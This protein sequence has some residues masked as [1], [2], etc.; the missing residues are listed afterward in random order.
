MAFLTDEELMELGLA[1]YGENVLI[2]KNASIYNPGKITIGNNVRIDDF[3]VLSAG[4]G[5]I[6]LGDYIH[7][8]VFCS[9]IGA[10]KI[11]LSDFCGLSSRVSIYSSNDDYSGQV[12]TN[13]TVPSKFGGVNHA[14]VTLGKHVVI[15]SGAIILPG[16]TLEEGSI[17]GAMS[18]VKLNCESFGIY[19]GVPARHM[20]KR[21]SALLELEAQLRQETS[22][23]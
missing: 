2:S 11:T 10:G 9:V 13:P 21:K 19:A 12:L 5:G 18:L 3:C 17:V 1:S 22:K 8:A 15:G 23:G 16:I 6:V 4:D 14:E 20:G 7:I